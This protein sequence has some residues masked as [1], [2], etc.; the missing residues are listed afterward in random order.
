VVLRVNEIFYSIQGESSY[1]GYPCVFV[2]LTGCNLRCSYCDTGYAYHQGEELEIGEILERVKAHRCPLVEITGGEPL[3]QA[4]TPLLV[5]RL[6]DDG[7]KVLV[8]TNGSLNIDGIDRRCI[9]IVD[10][11]C[12][13]SGEAQSNDGEN[14]ARLTATDEIKFV[15]GDRKDYEYACGILHLLNQ[16]PVRVAHIHFSP[17]FGTL[18]PD[19]LAGWMLEDCLGARLSLQIH[20]LVW[21]PER[22]GV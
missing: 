16:N 7:F 14:L 3:I 22:T 20:K 6:L 5:L 18:A 1:A 9:R 15:I 21:S 17:V 11:K 19:T 2:R 4:A 12:P 13:S 8:E 10:I